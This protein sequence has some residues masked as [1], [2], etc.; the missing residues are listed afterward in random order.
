MAGRL[1]LR[2]W[3][4]AKRVHTAMLSRGFNGKFHF[5]RALRFGLAE[6]VFAVGWGAF[7]ITARIVDIPTIFGKILGG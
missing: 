4:R 1:V 2:T 5:R 7:F 6:T 3:E